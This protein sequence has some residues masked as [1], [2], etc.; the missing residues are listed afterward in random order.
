MKP[1]GQL[2]LGGLGIVLALLVAWAAA[3]TRIVDNRHVGCRI[4]LGQIQTRET[5]PGLHWVIVPIEGLATVPIHTRIL[6]YKGVEVL[7]K[8]GLRIHMDITIGYQIKPEKACDA[9][10]Q[11]TDIES[12]LVVPAI[13]SALR[14]VASAYLSTEYYEKRAEVDA[15]IMQAL[16]SL[17]NPYFRVVQVNIRNV[18]LPQSVVEAIQRKIVAKQEAERMQFVLQKEQK[19]AERKKIEALGI[20][21]A[22]KLIAHSLTETYL[23]WYQ[24]QAIK[25]LGQSPAHTFMIV[26]YDTKLFPVPT[27]PLPGAGK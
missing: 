24:I 22:N 16:E 26:P 5:P 1:R 23:Q 3:G 20:A 10:L 14:K 15:G 7:A 21:E 11:Y 8:D 18:V 27:Y 12:G 13:R 9:L 6:D 2:A 19:E 17:E 4:R 25:D